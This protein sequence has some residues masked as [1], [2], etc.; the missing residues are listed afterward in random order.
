MHTAKG[1]VFISSWRALHRSRICNDETGRMVNWL[2]S[3]G[4]QRHFGGAGFPFELVPD[5]QTQPSCFLVPLC[6]AVWEVGSRSSAFTQGDAAPWFRRLPCENARGFPAAGASEF[7]RRMPAEGIPRPAPSPPAH[8][9]KYLYTLTWSDCMKCTLNKPPPSTNTSSV[10]CYL[11]ARGVFT[12]LIKL[13]IF[14]V[15]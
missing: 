1:P 3:T 9:H 7:P 11:Q 6:E 14:K 8:L 12:R 5:K 15:P 13:Q 2:T 4:W 10:L